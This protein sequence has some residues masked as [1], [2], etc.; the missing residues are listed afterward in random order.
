MPKLL[1]FLQNPASDGFELDV[2]TQG[3]ELRIELRKADEVIEAICLP[4]GE[5]RRPERSISTVTAWQGM[6]SGFWDKFYRA[7]EERAPL[8]VQ[9]PWWKQW[10]L[11]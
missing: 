4:F 2:Y 5:T 7:T 6:V 3:I 1:H 8:T 10:M 11:D 9:H